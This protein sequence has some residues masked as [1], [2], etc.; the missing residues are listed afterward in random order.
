MLS[1]FR[2]NTPAEPKPPKAGMVQIQWRTR[3]P[4]GK[5]QPHSQVFEDRASEAEI[6]NY[7]LS[8]VHFDYRIKKPKL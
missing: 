4:R 3:E 5:W 8:Q 2:A 7:N 1:Y 6:R